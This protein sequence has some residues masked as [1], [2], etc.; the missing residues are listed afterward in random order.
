M[1]QVFYCEE[2]KKFHD[3]FKLITPINFK[4]LD[5]DLLSFRVNFLKEELQ[6][7]IESYENNDLEIAIDSIIDLLYVTCG[8]WIY[9][10]LDIE[11]LN[12]EQIKVHSNISMEKS[13]QKEYVNIRID[14]NKDY[15]SIVDKLQH[16]YTIVQLENLIKYYE[17]YSKQ[18]NKDSIE[19]CLLGIFDVCL[20]LAA[21]MGFM[22][23]E[24]D[25]LFMDVQRANMSKERVLKAEDSK[26]GSLYDVIKPIG[27]QGPVTKDIINKFKDNKNEE[28]V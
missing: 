14:N 21:L 6:E 8:T 1:T 26:R 15:Y 17:Y 23:E 7:Y 25:I 18:E 27:W 3:K 12:K 4:F 10:G 2:V 16:G 11:N 24:F 13:Y 28:K 5:N 22:Q 19:L 9:H 20:N